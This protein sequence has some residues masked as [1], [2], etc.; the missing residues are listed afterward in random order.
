[1][2][3]LPWYAWFNIIGLMCLWLIFWITH[4]F[5][6][7]SRAIRI[8]SHFKS[9]A[10]IAFVLMYWNQSIIAA[11]DNLLIAVT[12]LVVP[13]IA[14]DILSVLWSLYSDKR[15]KNDSHNNDR[16]ISSEKS[17]HSNK[18]DEDDIDLDDGDS[19]SEE[20]DL[21]FGR[22]IGTLFS[23]GSGDSDW[24]QALKKVNS[25]SG[26]DHKIED[27]NTF[28]ITF[29]CMALVCSIL[30][31]PAYMAIKMSLAVVS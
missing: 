31:P 20:D 25:M 12:V 24:F 22:A 27:E 4:N 30:V 14:W 18:F 3:N 21:E 15:K 10:L 26:E 23:P 11:L 1:M 6:Q 2:L 17:A 28:A 5:Q 13:L 19:F 16:L 8:V 7:D 9:I 29:I